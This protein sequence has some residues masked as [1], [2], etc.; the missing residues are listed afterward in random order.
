[1]HSRPFY[2]D[3]VSPLEVGALK[4]EIDGHGVIEWALRFSRL[5]WPPIIF[6]SWPT[7]TAD[8]AQ[9]MSIPTTAPGY[10]SW[11]VSPKL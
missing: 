6:T 5:V 9:E 10:T 11:S 7:E 3:I 2:P 4:E 1:M 8:T